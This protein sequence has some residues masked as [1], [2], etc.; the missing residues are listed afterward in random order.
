MPAGNPARTVLASFLGGAPAAAVDDEDDEAMTETGVEG[1]LLLKPM[2]RGGWRAEGA[3]VWHM[4]Q[5]TGPLELGAG[6]G[7][8]L[9]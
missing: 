9:L 5:V 1:F 7:R 2:P 6:R 8:R 4:A 3:G